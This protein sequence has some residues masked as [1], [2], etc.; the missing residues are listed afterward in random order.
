MGKDN[1]AG[2]CWNIFILYFI[3]FFSFLKVNFTVDEI[4]AI[5]DKRHNIRNMSVIAH[6][7]HGNEKRLKVLAITF[8][9]FNCLNPVVYYNFPFVNFPNFI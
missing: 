8:I 6:V 4:R 1:E 5:M 9:S 2:K 3:L 7:D